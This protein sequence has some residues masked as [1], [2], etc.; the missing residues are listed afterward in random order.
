M[1]NQTI[2][3]QIDLLIKLIENLPKEIVREMNKDPYFEFSSKSFPLK[4]SE[5]MEE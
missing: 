2:E 4:K 5:F 3:R 1:S